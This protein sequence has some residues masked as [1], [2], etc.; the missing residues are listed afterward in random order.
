MKKIISMLVVLLAVFVIPFQA[1]AH[2]SVSPNESTV[3]SWETYTMKVPSEK[4]MASKKIVL[5]IAKG[6]SFE[7]Y[8]PVPGWTTTVDKKNGTVTWQTEGN[9]IEKGQFQRFSFIAKNPSEEGD[10]AW[11]AYQYYEDGSIVEWVGA[12]D[13]ETPHATTKILKESA[14]TTTGSHGEVVAGAENTAGDTSNSNDNTILLW[15]AV[16]ISVLALITGILA[17]LSRKK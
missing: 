7:S 2:V 15:T 1:S 4:E 13:S 6:V 8:E 10:V 9:G 17:I 5:K 3:K 12:E 14:Q 11:N 16:V